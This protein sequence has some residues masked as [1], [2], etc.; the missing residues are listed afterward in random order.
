M[1]KLIFTACLAAMTFAAN[2]QSRISFSNSDE[3]FLTYGVDF[4]INRPSLAFQ[5]ATGSATESGKGF[6]VGLVTNMS[7]TNRFSLVPRAE[8]SF[9]SSKVSGVDGEYNVKLST[10]EV[11]AHLK[12]NTSDRRFSPYVM[13]GPNLRI[14]IISRTSQDGNF[15]TDENLAIDL[16]LGLDIPIFRFKLSP[17]LRYSFGVSD[18]RSG[19]SLG[20]LSHN[21]IAFV[22]ALTGF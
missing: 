13:A 20:D 19:S 17:E 9:L 3:P 10:L 5:N 16:G 22:V 18:I 12:Y 8:L 4:G 11:M 15:F 6:R 21:N 14:P 2:A 1:K 7:F